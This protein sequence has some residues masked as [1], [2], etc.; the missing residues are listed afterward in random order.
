[1]K[2]IKTTLNLEIKENII[3]MFIK[4]TLKTLIL[5]IKKKLTQMFKKYSMKSSHHKVLFKLLRNS[6]TTYYKITNPKNFYLTL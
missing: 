5:Q 6:Y 3:Q 4:T 1:M 2:H